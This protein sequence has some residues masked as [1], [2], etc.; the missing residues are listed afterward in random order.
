MARPRKEIDRDGFEKLCGFM[1]TEEEIA[2][3]FDVSADTLQRWCKRTYG[4][5]FAEVYKNKT[6]D[7]KCTL[8]R[9]Q[10]QLAERNP[11]MAIFLG[12]QWLGQKDVST[13]DANITVNPMTGLTEEELRTLAKSH[14]T[15][16]AADST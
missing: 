16:T 12:K 6:A 1:C 14:G 5:G 3:F 11:T 7:A 13:T 9:Y 10:M 8:R 2:S 15:A 4:E